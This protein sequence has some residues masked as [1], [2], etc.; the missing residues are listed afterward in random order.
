[1]TRLDERIDGLEA[2][3]REHYETA[4][5]GYGS[6]FAEPELARRLS[7]L[8]VLKNARTAA[9]PE[10]RPD[11][12]PDQ[13]RDAA[14]SLTGETV[15]LSIVGLE[16]GAHTFPVSAQVATILLA[17]LSEDTRTKETTRA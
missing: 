3:L 1:M 17:H 16:S 12:V 9:I 2:Q 6:G 11:N 13:F 15:M 7:E 5:R 4:R 10:F 8:S 14:E